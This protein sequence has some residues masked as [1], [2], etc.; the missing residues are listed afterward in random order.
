MT[1]DKNAFRQAADKL[2]PTPQSNSWSKLETMLDSQA[3]DGADNGFKKAADNITAFPKDSS[4][5]R[6]ENM[7]DNQKLVEENK[8]YKKWFRWTSGV[9][10]M[11]LIGASGLF[12]YTSNNKVEA[13]QQM[14]YQIE[15]LETVD[16]DNSSLYDI[17]KLSQL[18]DAKLWTNI[19]EGG[20]KPMVRRSI[21]D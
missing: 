19:V 20:P 18:N 17:E 5:D 12:F 4:W 1:M 6:L 16:A 9:A 21:A 8:S 15:T 2:S 13:N 10:A 3:L 14:A 11:I 7:L